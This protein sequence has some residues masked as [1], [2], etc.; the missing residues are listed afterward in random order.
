[1]IPEIRISHVVAEKIAATYGPERTAAGWPSEWD[2]W[3]GPLAAALIGFRDFDNLLYDRR[4]EVRTLHLIDPIFGALVFVGV[5]VG[6]EIVEIAD[7]GVDPHY[8][9]LIETDPS[10]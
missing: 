7:F 2:F 3:S 10:D 4:R 1:M 9:E 6:P 5:L 8:W